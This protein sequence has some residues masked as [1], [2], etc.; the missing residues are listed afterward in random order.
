MVNQTSGLEKNKNYLSITSKGKRPITK[1]SFHV[2]GIILVKEQVLFILL[3]FLSRSPVSESG[4]LVPLFG[5]LASLNFNIVV[6]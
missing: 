2:M 6:L 3:V 1:S 4:P 5:L